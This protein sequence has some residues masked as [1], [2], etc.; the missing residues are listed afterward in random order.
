[1][2][3]DGLF[4]L[5]VNGY[6]GVDFNDPSI[7]P[8]ALDMALEA[9]LADGVTGCL[10]T[11]ITAY[12]AELRERFRALDAAVAGSRLG[13]RMVAGYH[14]E[15]PFLNASPGYAGCHPGGA[16]SDPDI[17][18]VDSL[19]AGLDRPILLVTLAPE[20]PGSI[21][22]IQQLRLRGKATAIGHSAADFGTVRRAADAGMVLSTHLGN[23]L[24]QQ[25]AKLEN[26]L[27]AQLA[28]PRLHACL[29]ADGHHMSPDALA[30]IVALKGVDRSILVTDAVLAAAA[31][32]G[33]YRFAGMDVDLTPEGAVVQPGR[34]NLA[35]SALRLDQAV[36]NVCAWNIADAPA[37]IAMA[38]TNA[39]RALAW[40]AERLGL[41]LNTGRIEWDMAL[42]PT[43]VGWND[44]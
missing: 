9:M 23:G 39:R 40:P 25:L 13:A 18:L 36:R 28:E 20:R 16:M 31:P 42:Q 12:P 8:L 10:P 29:I 26:T 4:D 35:G 3:S 15:G 43:F 11:I 21:H 1:M 41:A 22:F 33:H 34:A 37:A 7:T 2:L 27:L 17:A 38:S 24:P 19:E 44:N 32:P 30:A 5:Q 6:A 14:L